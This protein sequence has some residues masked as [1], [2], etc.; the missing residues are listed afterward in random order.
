MDARSPAAFD[1]M[2]GCG[3]GVR[4]PYRSVSEWLQTQQIDDLKR[5]RSEAEALFRRTGITFAVYGDE[6]AT[7]RLIPFDIIPR[8]LSAAEW[9]RLAAGIEQRVRALNAFMYDVYH[10]QEIIRAGRIPEDLI[11]Q[12]AA[13]LPE[14]MCVEPAARGLLARHRHRHRAHGRERV[15]RARG[16]YAHAV[17]RLLHAGEPRDHDAHV[18]G[19]VRAEPRGGGGGL[20]RQPAPD[21]RKRGARATSIASPPWRCS[22]PASTTAPTSST[23]SWPTRWGWSWWRDRT[24][25]VSDGALHDEDHAGLEAGRRH[26]PPH[27]RRLPRPAG[28]PA[29][30]GARRARHLRRLP[31]WPPH[32]RQRARRRHRRRQVDL[33]LH[34]RHRRVLHGPR[35]DPEERADLC[36]PQARRSRLRAGAPLR[37]GGEAGARLGRLRHA[38]RARPR[39]ATRSRCFACW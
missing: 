33:Y 23:R 8:I 6:A 9:R 20:P 35:A 13:F 5:K 29:R 36:V 1:E 14:M 28:V 21:A 12:N 38:G 15:L 4:E 3:T 16:Q 39:R 37:A 22:R 10:R 19:A 24:C 27:R 32:H 26:L 11:I 17:R 2:N 7:E 30:F 31:R 25:V 34:A 18:P